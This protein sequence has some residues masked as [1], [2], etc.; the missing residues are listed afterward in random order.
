MNDKERIERL[1]RG[2]L[3]KYIRVEREGGPHHFA[4]VEIFP[5]D[6][7]YPNI[8]DFPNDL[9]EQIGKRMEYLMNGGKPNYVKV[10]C[11]CGNHFSLITLEKHMEAEKQKTEDLKLVKMLNP[12][13][14]LMGWT[15]F[16]IAHISLMYFLIVG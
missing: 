3:P 9:S 7:R 12:L 5:D 4:M 14:P 13:I 16:A 1:S 6:P 11:E 15:L 2:E 8:D 10:E